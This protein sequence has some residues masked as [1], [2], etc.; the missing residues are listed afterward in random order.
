MVQQNFFP[1]FLQLRKRIQLSLWR[2]HLMRLTAPIAFNS[3]SSNV[4]SLMYAL[5]ITGEYVCEQQQLSIADIYSNSIGTWMFK[6]HSAISSTT[7]NFMEFPSIV[8]GKLKWQRTGWIIIDLQNQQ[9]QSINLMKWMIWHLKTSIL[10]QCTKS[11]Y[12]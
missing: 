7:F 11:M 3:S 5:L 12:V 10:I 9:T 6:A 1:L 8:A 4:S 2:S